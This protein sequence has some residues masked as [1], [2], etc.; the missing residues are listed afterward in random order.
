MQDR[1]I[2]WANSKPGLD[3]KVGPKAKIFF[4]NSGNLRPYLGGEFIRQ[5]ELLL[6]LGV[7]YYV[8]ENKSLELGIRDSVYRDSDLLERYREEDIRIDQ[9]QDANPS[10][11][12]GGVLRF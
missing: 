9:W 7:I 8:N 11:Y 12:F 6:G 2:G 10:L 1:Y 5:Q 4:T 3:P